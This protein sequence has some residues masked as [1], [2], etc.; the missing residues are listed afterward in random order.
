M[1]FTSTEYVPSYFLSFNPHLLLNRNCETR[2]SLESMSEATTTEQI[3]KSAKAAFEASQL[4]D[5]S[6]R[7]K[8]LHVIKEELEALKVEIKAANRADLEVCSI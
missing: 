4:V 1:S 5:S 7:V 3:A 8:A 6:E 2:K